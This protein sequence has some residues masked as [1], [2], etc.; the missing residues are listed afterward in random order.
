MY[1]V[2]E[3]AKM[4]DVSKV[5]IYKKMRHLKLEIKPFVVK[6]KN[7][8]YITDEGVELI[9]KMIQVAELDKRKSTPEVVDKPDKP[10]TPQ[11]ERNHANMPNQ[12]K[13]IVSDYR[14][15]L[16]NQKAYLRM[17]KKSK[18]QQIDQLLATIYTLQDVVREQE[19]QIELFEELNLQLSYK[20]A[21]QWVK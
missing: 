16:T 13:T 1:R 12:I 15:Q 19:E 18:H 3:V 20:E 7:V 9:K 8:T 17:V 10:R 6:E 11:N 4:L 14:Q 2:I 21:K 5:T